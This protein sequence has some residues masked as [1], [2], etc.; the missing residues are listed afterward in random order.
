M[1]LSS[2]IL[3]TLL[4]GSLLPSPSTRS[5]RQESKSQSLSKNKKPF[6]PLKARIVS[7]ISELAPP[8]ASIL[9]RDLLTQLL[10]Q[11]SNEEA[12]GLVEMVSLR[13]S[14]M[15]AEGLLNIAPVLKSDD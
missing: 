5:Q 9:M 12:I 4:P 1:S 3:K 14:E 7:V 15:R 6:D 2:R 10:S 11:I 8:E 13:I